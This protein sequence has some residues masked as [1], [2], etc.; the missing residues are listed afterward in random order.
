MLSH[1]IVIQL[2]VSSAGFA[3]AYNELSLRA[4][5]E[6][7]AHTNIQHAHRCAHCVLLDDGPLSPVPLHTKAKPFLVPALS[8]TGL[9]GIALGAQQL[10]AQHFGAETVMSFNVPTAGVVELPLLVTAVILPALVLFGEFVLFGGGERVAKMMG[11]HQAD[12]SLTALCSRVAER[13]GLPPPA[14][15]YEIPTPEL[16]AFAAGFGRSDATVAVT[17]G[18]RSALSTRELEAVLAHEMGHIRHSDM[19]TNMHAAIAVAGLG[20]LYELGRMLMDSKRYSDRDA[21]DD[22]EGSAAGLALPL[23]VG[24]AATRILAHLL[25]LSISRGAEYD[26]DRVAAE[27]CG[28]DAMISAL[29][30]IELRSAIAPRDEALAARGGA[31]AHAYISNGLSDKP[32]EETSGL[33]G[34]WEKAKRLWSTHPSTADRIAALQRLDELARENGH[35]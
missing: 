3:P 35:R 30:K 27:L 34:A 31:F 19:S 9:A 10:A 28:S 18:I 20:G 6:R 12:G 16:N 8:Y 33:N 32:E 13:A 5:H 26:A 15:V 24:G 11:G 22:N 29:S 17:S 21:N 14:H 25:Q 7:Q 2:V 23:M 4:V 1:F